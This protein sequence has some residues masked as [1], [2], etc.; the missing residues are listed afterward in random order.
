MPDITMCCNETCPRKER[1]WRYTAPP[2]RRQSVSSFTAWS[3]EAPC[4]NFWANSHPENI[5]ELHSE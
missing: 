4:E 1:C 2:S 5:K 3:D